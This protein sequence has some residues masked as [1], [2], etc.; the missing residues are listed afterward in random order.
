MLGHIQQ[1][2]FEG[3]GGIAPGSASFKKIIIKPAIVGDLTWVKASYN[4]MHGLIATHWIRKGNNLEL[5]VEIPANTTAT[6]YV[7]AKDGNSI[8][9]NGQPALD[10]ESVRLVKVTGDMVVLEIV[11]GKYKFTALMVDK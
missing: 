11:S 2:F 9:L 5:N 3:L 4:S 6:V 7:P 10:S 8:K 1:W